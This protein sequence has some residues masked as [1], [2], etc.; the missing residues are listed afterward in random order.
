MTLP[1]DPT[2]RLHHLASGFHATFYVYTGVETGLFAS[3]TEPRAVP[4]LAA[5]L[6]LHEPYVRGFCEAGLRWG[7]L[8][9]DEGDSPP[10]F[11]LSA[12]YADLL[13]EP[14]SASY[15]GDLFR[16][17][18]AHASEEYPDYPDRFATGETRPPSDR[19]PE[20][21]A[22]VE[23]STR[24]LQLIFCE[25]LLAELDA[26]RAALRGGRLLDVG[27][28][29]GHLAC[30][31]AERYPDLRVLGVDL[32]ADAIDGA[33]ARAERRDLADRVAFRR[34]SAETVTG[35]F[36]AA[37]FFMSLHEIDP[38]IRETLFE[39]L[40]GVLGEDGVIVAFD[41]V[42]PAQVGEY[43]RLPFA[44]GVETQWAELTLGADVPT[45]AA[46]RDLLAVAGFD[47]QLRNTFAERFEVFEA[48]RACETSQ[49]T[50]ERSP[51]TRT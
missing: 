39:R 6:G 42:Y 11:R 7:F 15:V 49:P 41:E 38:A 25:T 1:G 12:G 36:D 32:D 13:A 8:T 34:E 3:L 10:T 18:G 26:F 40:G 24:G 47:E 44:T 2:D 43:D 17:L 51:T 16:F 50:T 23:G 46:Q 4:A 45:R 35:A 27:C 29:T 31:L 21:T 19:G 48:T 30:A 14:D 5:D 9:A 33:R 37:V 20:Y 28:G 22:V